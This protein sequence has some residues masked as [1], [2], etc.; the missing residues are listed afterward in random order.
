MTTEIPRS[1]R[2]SGIERAGPLG[3]A[4]QAFGHAHAWRETQVGLEPRGFG[5]GPAR[6]AGW[7]GLE[8]QLRGFPERA[9]Q[10]VDCLDQLH[11]RATSDVVD[12]RRLGHRPGTPARLHRILDKG[13][14]ARLA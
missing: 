8:A 6:I 3:F 10:D 9:L 14:V 13:E 7:N 2:G 12:A 5:A 4:R 1:I 11:L